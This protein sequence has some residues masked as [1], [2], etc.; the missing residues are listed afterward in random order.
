L[1]AIHD[2]ENSDV[3]GDRELTFQEVFNYIS[4]ENEGLPYF[5]RRL[6]GVEQTPTIQG[7]NSDK[8]LIQF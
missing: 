6:H 4:N 1:K 5:A 2:F 8:R 3:N 7:G